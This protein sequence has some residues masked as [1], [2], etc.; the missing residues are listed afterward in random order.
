MLVTRRVQ[1]RVWIVTAFVAAVALCAHFSTRQAAASTAANTLKV[2]PVRSDVELAPGGKKTVKVTVT[3]LTKSALTVLPIEND[4]IAGDERGTP[5]LILDANKYAPTH[6]LKRFMAPLAAMTIPAS[7]SASVDV[8]ITTP[9]NAQAGGYFG[10]IRFAPTTPDGGGQVNLS[11]SVASLI[12]ATVPGPTVEKLENFS[13]DIEQQGRTKQYFTTP[14]DISASVRF[15]NKGN[16]Q[17]APFGKVSVLQDKK[18][19]YEV[20]FNNQTPRDMILPDSARRWDAPLKNLKSF[21]HYTVQ[22]TFSYGTKNQ[23][24]DASRSFWIIPTSMILWAGGGVVALIG[25][26]VGGWFALRAY[27]QRVLRSNHRHSAR[28]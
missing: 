7:S 23:T 18:V 15:E 8:V 24:I 25:L 16:L 21:G 26:I 12:L 4:F 14:N 9:S 1:T 28:R 17:A 11:A 5:A 13:F 6:S 10:A 2:T 3:N 22:A 19:I 20:D 27:K